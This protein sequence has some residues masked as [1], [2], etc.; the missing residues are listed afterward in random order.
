[1]GRDNTKQL[2]VW[3]RAEVEE[4]VNSIGGQRVV[5]LRK[6]VAPLLIERKWGAV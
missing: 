5:I 3:W 6:G 2:H 4:R 1:M